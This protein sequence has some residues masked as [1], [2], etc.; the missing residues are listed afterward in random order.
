M[1]IDRV[2]ACLSDYDRLAR[3]A[4]TCYIR[5]VDA[6]EKHSL[7]AFEAAHGDA[8]NGSGGSKL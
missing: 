4:R 1:R 8:N 6:E 3:G 7:K 5:N 2:R